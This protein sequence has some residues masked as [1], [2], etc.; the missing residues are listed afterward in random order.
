MSSTPGLSDRIR[1][2]RAQRGL[3]QAQAAQSQGMG[4]ALWNQYENAQKVPSA[5]S[6]RRICFALD[7]SADYLLGLVP[8]MDNQASHSEVLADYLC[9]R[10]KKR[11]YVRDIICILKEPE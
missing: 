8:E 6:L 3:T 7:V 9:L 5:D 2:A 4:R 10:Q 11:E 1:K